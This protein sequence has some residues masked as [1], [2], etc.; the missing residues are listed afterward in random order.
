MPSKTDFNVSPYYDDFSEAKKFHRVMYRPAFAVQARELT[1][2]QSIIQNQIERMGDHLFKH[3]AMVIPGQITLDVDFDAV[4]LTSFTGTLSNFV[5]NTLTGGTSG[6]VADVVNSVVTDGTDPDTL[7]VKYRNSGTDNVSNTFTDG[8][9][10]TSGASTGE[11]AVCNTTAVGSAANI[12][13]GVYYINGFFVQVDQQTLILDKYT[14]TPSYRIGLTITETFVTSTDDTSLLDNAQGSSNE[15]ATGAHRFKI[16]L[17]LAKLSLTSTADASFIELIRVQDGQIR[18]KIEKTTYNILEDTLARRTFDESGDYSVIPFELDIR[19]SL[20]SG[21]NR[22]IYS[23]GETTAE[24]NTTSESLLALGMSPGISFVKGYEIRKIGTTFLD[25][26][27]ARDFE[28]SSGEVTR[29]AQLPF[30][31]ITSLHGTPDVG[32]VSGETE[33]YKLI[34][35]KDSKHTT[36]GTEL[37]NNDGTVHDI[38]RAKSRGIEYNSGSFSGVFSSTATLTTNTYKHYLFDIVMFAHL[39]VRGPASGALTTGETLTGGTSGATAIVESLTSLGEATIT[40]ITQSQ[41]PIV[42]CSGGHNFREGQTIKIT[43]VSGMTDVNDGFFTVKNPSST[44]FELFAEASSSSSAPSPT[45]GTGFSAYTSSGTAAHTIVVLSNVKGEFTPGET[46]TGGSSSNTAVVQFNTH[47]T[48]G[49][50]QKAFN[51]TKGI[52]MAGSPTFTADVDLTSTFGDVKTLTGTISTVGAAASPGN[53]IMDGSDSDGTDSGDSIILEDATEAGNQDIAVGLEADV[54]DKIFGSGTEFTTELKI[55]DQIS[56]EDDSNNTFTRIVQAIISNTELETAVGL[57]TAIATNVAFKR[58]RTKIQS[59]QNDRAIFKL[60]YD[61]V[62][63]LLTEDNNSISDTSFKIRRQF[64]STLSSSGTAT[65]TAGTNEVFTAHSEA[66]VTVSVMTKGGSASAGEVGDVITL[67][68]SGDY[69]LGGSP[70]GKTL[71]IDLGS[72]F[73]GSKIKVLATISASVVSAK[74]KTNTTNQTI[75]VDT[76]ALAQ[77]TT[78][79]LAKADVHKINSIH[80]AADFSTAATTSDSDITDKFDLDTGQ[81]DN[82]YDIGRVVRKA[83]ATAPTGRLLINFDYFEHGAGNFF[84]VDSYAGFDYASIPSY[85][86]DVT[87]EKFELRDCLDFRPRVDNASTID[88]GGQDRSFDGTGA[89]T[90]EIAKFNSDITNDLEYYLSRRDKIYI[91]QHGKFEISK[92]QSE[93][94]PQQPESLD[95]AMLLYDLFLPAFTFNT[96]DIKIKRVDNRRYTMRDIG[97]L[98]QRLEN[99]EFYTQLSLLEAEAQNMQIQDADGFDRFKNGIIVDNFTGHGIGDVADNDYSI[100]M[101]MAQ[102]E[103]RPAFH[104]DNIGLSEIQSDLET[105]ITDAARATAG[106]QKT[107]DLITLPYTSVEYMSQPFASR[108]VNLNPYDTSGYIGHITLD[109]AIDEWIETERQ[110]EM[111]I[112]MPGSF[113]VFSDLASQGVIDLNLG[114]VWNN[115]NDMWSGTVQEVNRRVNTSRAGNTVTTTTTIDTEQRVGQR[116]TGVRTALVPQT[117]RT[118]FGDRVVNVA[119]ASFIRSRTISFTATDM[120]PDTRIFAFFDGINVSDFVTPTGSSQGAALTTDSNGAA[121]G[122]FAIPDPTVDSN[123]R[124]R[125]GTKTFRLTNSS[126]NSLTTNVFTS[127]EADY[128]AKGLLNSVQGTVVS[129]REA[130]IGRESVSQVQEITRRNQRRQ[131]TS[132]IVE[133]GGGGGG[134]GNNRGNG[135]PGRVI[136]GNRFRPNAPGG[137]PGR[138]GPPFRRDPVAQTFYVDANDGMF[139]TSIDL[140]FSAK[141]SSLPATVQ[142][143]TVVNGYPTA[144]V[145]P[146]GEVSLPAASIN[147]SSDASVATTFTFPSPVFLQAGKEYSFVALANTDDFQIYTARLGDRTLDDSRLISKQ[148][149]LGSMFKSQNGET[150]TPEQMEDVRFDINIAKF[151]TN[152]TGTVTLVNE[153]VPVKRLKQNPITTTSGS[154]DITIH[155]RNHGMHSTAANVTIAG[156]PSGTHNGIASTNINGTYTTI[157]NIKL[158]SYQVTAANSDT[159]SATGDVGG[160]VVTATRNILF[161]V[162][163]PVVGNVIPVGTTLTA[164]MRKTGGRTLEGSETEYS[165]ATASKKINVVMNQDYYMTSPGMVASSINETNEMSGSKSFV[166]NLELI[167]S[168]NTDNLSPVIDTKRLSAHLIQNRLFSPVSGTT[169][170]FVAETTN[171]GGSSPAKYMTRPVLLKNESTALDV[172]LSASIRSS[173]AVK[174]F[175]R[176]TSVDDV[177]LLGNVAWRAFNDDGT[178]DTAVDPSNTDNDF[179][180]NKFTV[181]DLPPFSAFALKIVLTGTNSSYPPIVKDM[182]GIALAV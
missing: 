105:T 140:F 33:A 17:T 83:G 73:N 69:A 108:T 179:K 161:D 8:E 22:G 100:S 26:E 180:E 59:A 103:L 46:C 96:S 35:L 126:V 176:T 146:F 152:T 43:S 101:D 136:I 84:S 49:F 87:G 2:Q 102:G 147:T 106:Y 138:F 164:S 129:T 28:S 131:Q 155:H 67:S 118:S 177:R 145:L 70:T 94:N 123:P 156:V 182:R 1:T 29:F 60:P 7:F 157:K 166:L 93:I 124:F 178:P 135:P 38:G 76:Q 62:K 44:T 20:I 15:N 85:T 171:I 91:D 107:G 142:L 99:V 11:T 137:F 165:L 45:D 42:T 154:A 41:P 30:V 160:T 65:L 98:E 128:V 159:A 151:T 74:T 114:T 32:F 57:G 111:L 167:T 88:A 169:P 13:A 116:R 158:D 58:N 78:I 121:S 153:E 9:T 181:S 25:L 21:N 55:G 144:E 173:S 150:W 117:V 141:S 149:V 89:S 56:F 79:S 31:N 175:Y 63:T 115:W 12:D 27:K 113:D 52:S 112:D 4:K 48:K 170:D 34:S 3:G 127:A 120:K 172:R 75:T 125:T 168:T 39:N 36:R 6:V 143:R 77:A 64:V 51:Q 66:D 40:G 14:N 104:Q 18:T 16:N 80:M 92:G 134:G 71:T 139:V 68:S 97:R 82:F 95:D 86:S 24:N 174:M 122:T 110:P 61:V 23:T 81:R 132:Q 109:P 10:L 72:T 163:Q 19:E 37:T 119:F 90:I 54:A 133:Q 130:S 50:E 53:I 5:G 162:I 148:P 47:G